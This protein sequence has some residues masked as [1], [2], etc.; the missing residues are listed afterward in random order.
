MHVRPPL[1]AAIAFAFVLGLSAPAPAATIDVPPDG[2]EQMPVLYVHG[3][4]DDGSGWARDS[5]YL[6]EQQKESLSLKYIRHYLYGP[7]SSPSQM[8]TTVGM[9]NW[10][11]QWW[12]TNV[13]GGYAAPDST[14]EEGFAFL[15]DA[16]ELLNGTNWVTGTWT[17]QNR[18]IPSAMEVLT[19]ENFNL[20]N[21]AI[22]ASIGSGTIVAP[23]WQTLL[24]FLDEDLAR[25]AMAAQLL[26][27]NTYNDS[28]RID[29]R[30][31]NFLDLLRR[32][33]RPGGKLEKWRQVNVITHSMG[34]LVTRAMLHKADE[35]SQEDSEFVANVIYNAPPFGGSTMGHLGQLYFGVPEF[36]SESFADPFL[37]KMFQEAAGSGL[38]VFTTARAYYD[39]QLNL[40]LQPLGFDLP[41]MEDSLPDWARFVVEALDNVPVGSNTPPS[42]LANTPVGDAIAFALNLVRPLAGALTGMAGKPGVGDLTP[43]GGVFHLQ[44]YPQNPHV[45]QFITIGRRG[46]KVQLFPDDLSAV[47]ANP[48][49][50]AD[51]TVNMGQLDD[52]AVAVGSA[53]LLTTTD[54]FGPRMTSLGEFEGIHDDMIYSDVGMMAPIWLQTYLAPRT[55]LHLEGEVSVVD[56]NDRTYL[57]EATARFSFS[58]PPERRTVSLPVLPGLPFSDVTVEVTATG[59]QYRV[60]PVEAGAPSAWTD[61]SPGSTV[62]FS[63]LVQAHRLSNRPFHLE[64]RSVNARGGRE[65]I[66]SATIVVIGEAPQV[67]EEV[68]HTPVPAEVHRYARNVGIGLKAVRNATIRKLVAA[69]AIQQGVLAAI[70]ARPESRWAVRNASSK[71]LAAI[72]DMRGDVEYAWDDESFS[73]PVRRTGVNGLAI[74][75]AGLAEGPHTLYFETSKTTTLGGTT[76]TRRSPRQ[77]IGVLVDNTAPSVQFLGEVNHPVGRVVGPRTPLRFT[78]EDV[79][80]NGGTGTM[81][82]PGHPGGAVSANNTFN[83]GET[84]LREQMLAAGIAGGFV[85]LTVNARDA[86]NN[87]RIETL[88]VFYDITGPEITLR[89]LSGA[90][91]SGEKRFTTVQDQLQIAVDVRDAAAG[92]KPPIV[93]ISSAATADAGVTEP[94]TVGAIGTLP[95]SFAGLIRLS[96]GRNTVIVSARDFADNLGTLTLTIDRVDNITDQQP[97]DLLSTRV[98]HNIFFDTNGVPVLRNS[99]DIQNVSCDFHGDVFVFDSTSNAFVGGDTNSGNDSNR[100]RDVFARRYGKIQRISVAADGTQSND[101]SDSPAVSGNGR[102]AVF[103]SVATN[104]IPGTTTVANASNLYLKDLENGRIALI[105]RKTDGTPSNVA[106][107]NAFRQNAITHS[108]RYVFFHSTSTQHV[109]GLTDVNASRDVFMLDLDPDGDGDFFEENYVTHAISTQNGNLTRTSNGQSFNPRISDDGRHVIFRSTATDIHPDTAA[110]PSGTTNA[111][112]IAF[113]GSDASGNLNVASR[114][115]YPINRNSAANSN[116]L[117]LS[118]VADAAVSPN[119]HEAVFSTRSNVANSGDVNNQSTGTDVYLALGNPV[120]PFIAWSSHSHD[121][122]SPAAMQSSEN[123]N[124]PVTVSLAL[125][126]PGGGGL[127]KVGWVSRHTNIE[128]N[129]SNAVEDLFIRIN[130][131]GTARNDLRV[132]NWISNTQPSGA[133]VIEGGLSGDGRYAWWVT[134][135]QYVSPYSATGEINLYRRRLDP[136]FTKK[137]TVRT[138][139]NGAGTVER[140]PDGTNAGTG[141]FDYLDTDEVTLT[142]VPNNGSRFERWEGADRANANVATVRTSRDRIVN[143]V[144]SRRPPPMNASATV[145]TKQDETSSGVPVDVVDSGTAVSPARAAATAD[146]GEQQAYAVSIVTQPQN[147]VA[148]VRHNLLHYTPNPGFSG[149]DSFTFTVTNNYGESLP[150]P[151]TANVIVETVNRAPASTTL[152]INAAANGGAVVVVPQVAD[153]TPGDTFTFGIDTQPANGTAALNGNQFIYTPHAGFTGVDSF[154]YRVTDSNGQ[155]IIGIAQ[156][157]VQAGASAG[158]LANISTR[159]AIGTDE[160][161]LIGGFIITGDAAKNVILRGIAPSLASSGAP[162]VGALADPVLELRGSGGQLL[163]LNDDWRAT[164]EGEIIATTIPPPDDR[165]PALIASLP[166]GA[167]TAIM[168]GKNGAAGVGL[169]ELYDLG[170]P[171]GGSARLANISTRGLVQTGDNVMIGGL[172][173]LDGSTNVIVRAI[174]PTLSAAG[175]AGALQ[176][177]TLELVDGNG[178]TLSFNDDWRDGS[179]E[180]QI[181]ASSIPPSNDREAAIVAGLQPGA[182]TAIVRGKNGAAGV[183]LVEAYALP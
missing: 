129:D 151:V 79:G 10:A 55:T 73:N 97:L 6:I 164:Q 138:S 22:W 121:T 25:I 105:S 173:L 183:A 139:G 96:P 112:R 154:I 172:I 41:S 5:L 131:T 88:R 3:Y 11:V 32:E 82:V 171:G 21:L 90:T 109:S 62:R 107:T 53:K 76:V 87:A 94:L 86:V 71:A 51:P 58:S 155:T 101:H 182:Y 44:N 134:Q 116:G 92:F 20:L 177:P 152:V 50:I 18:P 144:F 24:Q 35:F 40:L 84:N 135:Q 17:T 169:V 15:Q 91:P 80:S 83:L 7:A 104:L 126:E 111:V 9:P 159:L 98:P 130:D 174:G 160:N 1:L 36:R 67:V 140:Q 102:Y 147:G 115:V 99:G 168:S 128:P 176:D 108:G 89:Q 127:F 29:P 148:F 125:H 26:I 49:M 14:V 123:I 54:N 16:Q 136:L 106:G 78:V 95:N 145:R 75:L 2:P 46:F 100:I 133:R 143:A 39:L 37:N 59:H 157:T 120:S 150:S 141:V 114:T 181:I 117:T 81:V 162:L 165:E 42:E 12:S 60:L 156:I 4:A 34:S 52:T 179:Q 158:K 64:W 166:P 23:Q 118:G 161:V 77:R 170:N 45:A 149:N 63:D 33:R 28:G 153:A 56:S 142:A 19:T 119:S 122:S 178:A 27:T 43:A 69:D 13:N 146:D 175:V 68:I 38:G 48:N 132:I 74:P 72:F 93:Q 167:Y 113:A 8:F 85:D 65:M 163:R 66:R 137:L 31:Q 124:A 57:A 61:L 103:R 30:A 47:A 180:A 70:I 110:T